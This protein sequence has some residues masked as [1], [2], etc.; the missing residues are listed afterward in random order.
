M[1]AVNQPRIAYYQN[2]AKSCEEWLNKN[3]QLHREGDFPARIT[4][5]ETGMIETKEWYVNGK[6]HRDDLYE[7]AFVSYFGNGFKDI[8]EWYQNGELHRE[9]DLPSRIEYDENN[10]NQIKVIEYYKNGELHREHNPAI[11]KYYSTQVSSIQ[12]YKNRKLH[13]ENEASIIHF[14][15]NGQMQSKSYHKDGEFIGKEFAED[16][17]NNKN[18]T[19]LGFLK[20][21]KVSNELCEF[22]NLDVNEKHS[23]VSVTKKI[24]N[25]IINNNLFDPNNN[26]VIVPDEK[27]KTLLNYKGD[28]PLTHKNLQTY[29]K[30]HF[31]V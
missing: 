13:N 4:Y 26:R 19:R 25:Y 12:Y 18:N 8:E 17:E 30:S 1:E 27:L 11:I 15:K 24:C 31:S 2:G 6:R 10:F 7:P 16:K 20:P 14:D 3:R 22:F 5:Y 23:R 28:I 21:I 9:S 29:L